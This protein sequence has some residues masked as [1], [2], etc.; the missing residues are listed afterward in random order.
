[1]TFL[2]KAIRASLSVL[3]LLVFYAPWFGTRTGALFSILGSLVATIAWFMMGNPFGI[4]NAYVALVVP[5]I[6]MGLSSTAERLRTG[7][8]TRRPAAA[9]RSAP[10]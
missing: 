8:I 4:D 3:V 7:R 6:I 5:L 9:T 10:D 2:A 1:M